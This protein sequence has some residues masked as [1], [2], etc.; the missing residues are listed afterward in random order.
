MLERKGISQYVSH[1]LAIA[2]A[3]VILGLVTTNFYDYYRD[4]VQESQGAEASSLSER[5]GDEIITMY[6]QYN[7][8]EK[9]PPKGGSITFASS[10]LS[11]PEKIGGSNYRIY[12]NSSKEHWINADLTTSGEISTIETKRPAA[13]II[14]KTGFPERTYVHRLYN[15]EVDMN[16]SAQNPDK[17]ELSYVRS[18]DSQGNITDT[19]I[20]ERAS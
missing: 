20:L 1:I 9:E 14:V 8:N 7:G 17:I 2:I 12:L 15:I 19:V 6:T 16:G 18:K 10:T 11:A 3:F 4:V 13:M 5:I